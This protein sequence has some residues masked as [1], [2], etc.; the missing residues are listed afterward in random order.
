MSDMTLVLTRSPLQE[1][2]FQSSTDVNDDETGLTEEQR[3][4]LYRSP[5]VRS[6]QPPNLI[7]YSGRWGT[8]A[9]IVGPKISAV[10][11]ADTT[12]ASASRPPSSPTDT[13][14]Y[15][16]FADRELKITTDG[17]PIE[18][19]NEYTTMERFRS[20]H[21][22]LGNAHRGEPGFVELHPDPTNP[23]VIYYDRG[24]QLLIDMRPQPDNLG[25]HIRIIG[26]NTDAERRRLSDLE[27]AILIHE[28]VNVT[29]LTGCISPRPKGNRAVFNRTDPNN[30]SATVMRELF[31]A[32]K[33]APNGQGSLYVLDW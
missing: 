31:V 27:Q 22:Y 28:A 3:N 15:R 7:H 16:N 1:F 21:G 30:P 23:Y 11:L 26:G 33:A 17:R 6:D 19:F 10:Q 12:P 8:L 24:Y 5:R 29:W 13:T 4:R 25:D 32:V 9:M 18:S 2:I 20:N 14:Q